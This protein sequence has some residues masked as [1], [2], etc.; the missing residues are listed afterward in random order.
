VVYFFIVIGLAVAG[1]ISIIFRPWVTADRTAPLQNSA[2]RPEHVAA[3]RCRVVGAVAT[4]DSRLRYSRYRPDIQRR[5]PA[6]SPRGGPARGAE[7]HRTFG[8]PL[9]FLG[10]IV[11]C[12]V[13]YR[14][15]QRN[16]WL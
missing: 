5:A 1:V 14:A 9:V 15:F 8:Y 6:T 7:L 16:G 4:M 13:I 11:V 3:P 10:I 2:G 12:V